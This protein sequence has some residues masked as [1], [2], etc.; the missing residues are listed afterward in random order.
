MSSAVAIVGVGETPFRRA[1]EDDLY[2]LLATASRSA[3][4]DA[5]LTVADVDGIV[6]TTGSYSTLHEVLRHLGVTRQVDVASSLHAAPA[7]VAAPLQAAQMIAAGR[8]HVVLAFS[9]NDWG[10]Q[11]RGHTGVVHAEMQMKTAF[12]M[13]QG[14]YPQVVHFAGMA[15][16]RMALYGMNE[17]QLGAV[18]VAARRHAVLTGEQAVLGHKPLTLEQYLATPYLAEPYRAHD[19]CVVNDGAAAFVVTSRER[20]RDLARRPVEVLGVGLGI[21][22]MGEYSS[23]RADY[24]RT[25]AIHSA[26]AAFRMAGLE[27]ADVDFLE[28]YDNFTGMVLQAI[29]DLGFCKPGEAGEF[30]GGGRIELGGELPISTAG[31]QLAGAFLF[32]A[33]LVTEAVKQLRGDCGARQVAGAEVGLVAGYAGAEHATLL[34]G[35]S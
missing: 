26:P 9:G 16:R 18:A 23:L 21:L 8:A 11:R 15:R 4:D 24:L 30:V 1:L 19:C 33:N 3:L 25:A 27:P 7:T 5:G 34:L 2:T 35:R 31:G 17:E 22:P 13:P 10:S 6:D 14:W 32:G 29:E 12:E 28:L 20:A